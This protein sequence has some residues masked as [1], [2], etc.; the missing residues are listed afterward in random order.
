MYPSMLLWTFGV[1]YVALGFCLPCLS[2]LYFLF[3]VWFVR[4]FSVV[5]DVGGFDVGDFKNDFIVGWFE[6]NGVPLHCRWYS[7]TAPVLSALFALLLQ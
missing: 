2:R 4:E 5:V 6:G 7:L 1:L 3:L